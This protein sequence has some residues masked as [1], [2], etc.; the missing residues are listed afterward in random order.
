MG[1]KNKIHGHVTKRNLR[2]WHISYSFFYLLSFII[3]PYFILWCLDIFC[4]LIIF[5]ISQNLFLTCPVIAP[6]HI[7]YNHWITSIKTSHSKKIAWYWFK[8][9]IFTCVFRTVLML[10]LDWKKA[11][12]KNFEITMQN[13]DQSEHLL[14][15]IP[16]IIRV[17]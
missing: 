11:V 6:V 8:T 9:T 13:F 2:L 1:L 7:F 10:E 12:E 3:I 14:T 17:F 15:Q 4:F 16:S 5:C